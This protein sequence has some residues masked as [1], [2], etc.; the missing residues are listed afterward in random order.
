MD[1]LSTVILMVGFSGIADFTREDGVRTMLDRSRVG[2]RVLAPR[3]V[4][5]LNFVTKF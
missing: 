2:A 4:F 1:G 5:D 3:A